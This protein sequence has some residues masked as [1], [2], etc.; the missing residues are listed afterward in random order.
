MRAGPRSGQPTSHRFVLEA[1]VLLFLL[2]LA[3]ELLTGPPHGLLAALPDIT[4]LHDSQC[5]EVDDCP[6]TGL[7]R[8]DDAERQQVG[9]IGMAIRVSIRRGVA[10]RA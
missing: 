2:P 10:V 8:R 1:P 4:R 3:V 9:L 7:R 6:P 5:L